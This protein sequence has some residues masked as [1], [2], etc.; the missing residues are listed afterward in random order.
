MRKGVF[1]LP[2]N[3]IDS[4]QF[5]YSFNKYFIKHLQYARHCAGCWGYNC[6]QNRHS[7]CPQGAYSLVV[8]QTCT[9]AITMQYGKCSNGEKTLRG[10]LTQSCM[11]G[12]VDGDIPR[13]GQI[14]F[15]C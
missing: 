14:Q 6:E 4:I 1:L 8:I 9:Q 12:M 15:E 3:Q 5:I 13:A 10:H 7:P 2:L 11:Q